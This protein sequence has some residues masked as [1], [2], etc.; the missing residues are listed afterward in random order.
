VVADTAVFIGERAVPSGATSGHQRVEGG[1]MG[2]VEN[3]DYLAGILRFAS[4]ARG[5]VEVSRV[6]VGEQNDYG[7]AVHGT[8]GSVAWDFRRLGELRVSRGDGYQDLPLARAFAKPGDGDYAAFQPGAA[9][10][11]GYDDLKVIEAAEFVRSIATGTARGAGLDDAV[12]AATVAEALSD[13]A[14]SG[15]WQQVGSPEA[16]R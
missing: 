4:G 12:R 3:E 13:S 2:A 6:A 5:T 10:S 1:E 8:R 14:A 9:I 15:R 11:M 16:A 7:F